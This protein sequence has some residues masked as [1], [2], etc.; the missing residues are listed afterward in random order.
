M[1]YS[2]PMRRQ[3]NEM[4]ISQDKEGFMRQL[5]VFCVASHEASPTQSMLLQ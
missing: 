5:P 4:G 3:W 1:C 2:D